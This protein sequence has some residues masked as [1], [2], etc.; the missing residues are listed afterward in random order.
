MNIIIVCYFSIYDTTPRAFRARSL[1]ESLSNLGHTVTVITPAPANSTNVAKNESSFRASIKQL[2]RRTLVFLLPDGIGT[3]RI[4]FF[5]QQMK[6]KTSDITISVG[7]P[8]TVHLA[9]AISIH[10]KLLKTKFAIAD[11]GDPYSQNPGAKKCFYAKIMEKWVVSKFDIITIPTIKA[12]DAFTQVITSKN[13][14][15]VIP[16]GYAINQNHAINYK[17]NL[18]PNFAYAGIL[19]KLIRNPK[20]FFEYLLSADF[21]F[22]FHIY[23][24]VNNTETMQILKPYV[25]GLG[26]K[27][28]VH[29]MIPREQCIKALSHMDFLINFSN[30][31]TSQ[32]PSKIVDYTISS[33]PFL[34]IY[35]TQVEFKEFEMF[36]NWDYSA[37]KSTDISDYD[38]NK[39]AKMFIDCVEHHAQ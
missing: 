35:Q 30:D 38:E 10:L 20:T 8:F 29:E 34:N 16:Q 17:K 25:V 21:D 15:I 32:T 39:V 11:Y 37:F 24:D 33:R 13:K 23:T 19:Y 5:I 22:R 6:G 26:E 27:L 28:I 36:I 31:S 18:I 4:P 1:Y 7:L 14:L 2:V 3:F 9:T 12:V